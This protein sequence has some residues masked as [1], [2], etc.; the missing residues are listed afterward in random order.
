MV[1]TFK[2]LALQLKP[3][4]DLL[5]KYRIHKFSFIY[6]FI[7]EYRIKELILKINDTAGLY[8]YQQL[9]NFTP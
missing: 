7:K 9:N 4:I 3:I 5:Y 8:K 1:Q 2:H 6:T